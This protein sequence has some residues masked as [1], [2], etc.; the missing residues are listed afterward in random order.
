[1]SGGNSLRKAFDYPAIQDSRAIAEI[2]RGLHIPA[3]T[4]EA[5]HNEQ[6]PGRAETK[7]TINAAL[8]YL[9]GEA[10]NA[11]G[12][13]GAGGAVADGVNGYTDAGVA[14]D[15]AN[16][17][18]AAMQAAGSGAGLLAGGADT[19]TNAAQLQQLA[20][21]D[22]TNTGL[23]GSG[24]STISPANLMQLNQPAPVTDLS[25]QAQAQPLRA[26][27]DYAARYAGGVRNLGNNAYSGAQSL[28]GHSA[29]VP[30]EQ[31][32]AP[33]YDQ[34]VN[35][36]RSGSSGSAVKNLGAQMGLKMLMPQQ[37][38]PPTVGM[39]APQ[40]QQGPLNN[41]YQ[42]N[43]YGPGGNSLGLSEDQKQKLRAMG[44]QIP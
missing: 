43:P 26:I 24:G 12:G 10:G 18:N 27:Q 2:G 1:M 36:L 15:Q 39:P 20:M 37:R 6:N 3:L 38:P 17:A 11:L 28:L 22:M 7:A 21:Q 29:G 16:A 35:A 40:G 4:A 41:P 32:G 30:A 42:S 13:G 19:A 23:L 25:V 8:W 34:S 5:K 44:Y 14:L 9:G 31:A 33:V